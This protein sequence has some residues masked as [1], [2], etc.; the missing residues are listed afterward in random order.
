[1]IKVYT[2]PDSSGKLI[3]SELGEKLNRKRNHYLG[4]AAVS[5]NIA[6]L[7]GF[8]TGKLPYNLIFREKL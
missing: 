2:E 4:S 5:S 3:A 8:L 1:M 6:E 7:K